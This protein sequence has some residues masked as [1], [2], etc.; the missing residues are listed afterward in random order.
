MA[1]IPDPRH[2]WDPESEQ[3]KW[4]ILLKQIT[5]NTGEY[6]KRLN[7]LNGWVYQDC[8]FTKNIMHISLVYVEKKGEANGQ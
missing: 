3:C 4:E 8:H 1:F 2:E 6:V 7:V 5:P